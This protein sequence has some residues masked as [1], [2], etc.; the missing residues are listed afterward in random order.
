MQFIYSVINRLTNSLFIRMSSFTSELQ[1][2]SH[3]LWIW[4][5]KSFIIN[6]TCAFLEMI[7]ISWNLSLQFRLITFWNLV[8]FS[9]QM[10]THSVF[11]Y[12]ISLKYDLTLW[13]S[14]WIFE[15]HCRS[16]LV[17]RSTLDVQF[18]SLI[19]LSSSMISTMLMNDLISR[20][21]Y[22]SRYILRNYLYFCLILHILESCRSEWDVSFDSLFLL[23]IKMFM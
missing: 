12:C 13:L 20:W 11:I 4:M 21:N 9:L 8:F 2:D 22:L 10:L 6:T 15:S 1:N 14:S 3:F 16:I 23:W 5:T 18:Q 19:E 17:T 7:K